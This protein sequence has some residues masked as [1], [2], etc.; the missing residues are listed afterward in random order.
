MAIEFKKEA[1]SGAYPEIWRGECKILPGGFKP[2]QEFS[3]GTVLRRATPIFVDF[4]TMSAAVCKRAI[5]SL[6]TVT[7]LH[8]PQSRQST[9]RTPITMFSLSRQASKT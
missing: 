7:A 3:V 2:L 5:L 4:G 9:S 8:H 6:S 1:V